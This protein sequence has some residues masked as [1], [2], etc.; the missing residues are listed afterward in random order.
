M[1]S[2]NCKWKSHTGKRKA[3]ISLPEER[4]MREEKGKKTSQT[5]KCKAIIASGR[6]R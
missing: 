6:V 2:Y 1:K 3:I 5:G 4:F